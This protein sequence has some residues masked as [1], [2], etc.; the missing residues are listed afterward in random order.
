MKKIIYCI[1]DGKIGHLRQSEGLAKALQKLRPHDYDVQILPKFSLWQWLKSLGQCAKKI[2][3][4]S[5]VVG[6]GHRTHFSLLYYKWKY[7]AKSIVIMKP[8]LPKVWFDYCI[9]PKHDGLPERDNVLVT[10]GAMNALSLMDATKEDQTLVL[11]GGPSFACEWKNTH[12]YQELS[13]R[14]SLKNDDKKIILSTS[15]RTP[16]DFIVNLPKDILDKSEIIDFQVVD[17]SW[18]PK[19]LLKSKEAWV[20]AESISMIY[21][22]LSAGC[23]V[24]IIDV[25]GLKGK[26]AQ[27]LNHLIEAH[28]VNSD[29]NHFERLNESGRIAQKLLASGIMND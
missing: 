2:E 27:N 15:R 17:E 23:L 20:T 21:E 8:S 28:K 5:L 29:D 16:Q 4:N 19:Q 1:S 7:A 3:A 12:V 24:K 18:L 6:A 14:I 10:E 25:T 26:I 11:I 13:A 9:V 22:S